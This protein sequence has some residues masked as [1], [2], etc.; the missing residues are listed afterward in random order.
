MKEGEKLSTLIKINNII[1]NKIDYGNLNNKNVE[2]IK[3]NIENINL[4]IIN[5]ILLNKKH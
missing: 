4:N 3:R 5:S 1:E 2:D